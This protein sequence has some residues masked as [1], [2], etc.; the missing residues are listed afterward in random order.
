MRSARQQ[1]K[2]PTNQALSLRPDGSVAAW[3][4]RNKPARP[5]LVIALSR[6]EQA[7]A[8]SGCSH[9]RILARQIVS[10]VST[11]SNGK[12]T[13]FSQHAA[14]MD[15]LG[16]ADEAGANFANRKR[17]GK[18]GHINARPTSRGWPGVRSGGPGTIL[19]KSRSNTT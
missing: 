19:I 11:V 2:P 15:L 5:A 14:P 17:E 9:G 18:T 12:V 13:A 8:C 7:T 16:G 10:I 4:R 6:A 1:R 3:V